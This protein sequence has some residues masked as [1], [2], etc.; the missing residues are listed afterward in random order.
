MRSGASAVAINYR[1]STRLRQSGE[2]IAFS[3]Y[4]WRV[5]FNAADP[6]KMTPIFG[7]RDL[8][9]NFSGDVAGRPPLAFFYFLLFLPPPLSTGWN[10][11][12]G[13]DILQRGHG[14]RAWNQ[15]KSCFPRRDRKAR[16]R[17][18]FPNLIC[19]HLLRANHSS[20]RVLPLTAIFI[21]GVVIKIH[22]AIKT[23]YRMF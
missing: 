5:R 14:V 11:N 16:E 17:G 19:T 2:G 4:E 20:P 6:F 18:S 15:F 21:S 22:I 23:R 7:I 9:E 12:R 1:L 13:R 8:A 10:V 3:A